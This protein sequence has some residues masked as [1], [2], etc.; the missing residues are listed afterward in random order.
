MAAIDRLANSKEDCWKGVDLVRLEDDI[1]FEA[2][3]RQFAESVSRVDEG[4]TE[5]ALHR[6]EESIARMHERVS[7]LADR[8]IA[9]EQSER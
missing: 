1:Q 7:Q 6:F 5:V 9:I 8:F 4:A 2:S 3:S